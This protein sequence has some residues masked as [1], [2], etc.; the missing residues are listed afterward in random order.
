MD[1]FTHGSF[2]DHPTLDIGTQYFTSCKD[3]P[4]GPS[5]PFNDLVDPRGI[6]ASIVN[7]KYFY[8]SDNVV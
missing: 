7:D 2:L 5:A 1:I 8:G 3:N 4:M 6:L